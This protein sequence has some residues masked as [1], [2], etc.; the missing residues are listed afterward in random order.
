MGC[1]YILF[2]TGASKPGNNHLF[3]HQM[4]VFQLNGKVAPFT[5]QSKIK[6]HQK[7]G[8]LLYIYILNV[9][10]WIC[11]SSKTILFLGVYFW[12]GFLL[13]FTCMLVH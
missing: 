10:F 9:F 8:I 13:L 7:S 3:F 4:G 6:T 11:G 1:V 5:N 2:L 12:L